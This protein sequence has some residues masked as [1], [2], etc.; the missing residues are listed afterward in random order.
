MIGQIL[1]RENHRRSLK[2]AEVLRVCVFM[3]VHLDSGWFVISS[4]ACVSF[5]ADR[6]TLLRFS[7]RFV[8][9]RE[10]KAPANVT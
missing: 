8:R 3:R 2:D 7:E 4:A 9:M 6:L 5:I 10:A 1:K